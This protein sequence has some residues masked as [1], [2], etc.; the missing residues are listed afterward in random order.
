MANSTYELR[1]NTATAFKSRPTDEGEFSGSAD[2]EGEAYR[3]IV[4][5][6]E[7]GEKHTTRPVSFVPTQPGNTTTW[8]GLVF[9]NRRNS[10][11]GQEQALR[12]KQPVYSG[13][14]KCVV[15][16]ELTVTK[17][18]AIWVRQTKKQEDWMSVSISDPRVPGGAAGAS[19]DADTPF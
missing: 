2:I 11:N 12:E 13:T 18:V 17:R 15:S 1:P 4:E 9:D 19:A 14:V 3:V 8:S 6:A 16:P 7:V 5:K 10:A